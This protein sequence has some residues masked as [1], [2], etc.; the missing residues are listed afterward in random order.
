M[1]SSAAV[2]P[3]KS[4]PPLKSGSLAG[5]WPAASTHEHSDITPLPEER[6]ISPVAG[7]PVSV[8]LQPPYTSGLGF[9]VGTSILSKAST[10]PTYVHLIEKI[11]PSTPAEK[12]G[13]VP[14]DHLVEI[15]GVPCCYQD[16]DTIS[17]MILK[18]KEVG[19]PIRIDLSRTTTPTSGLSTSV[20]DTSIDMAKM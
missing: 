11:K 17:S 4:D 5:K 12:A 1:L 7:E 8:L 20:S 9:T 10:Y 15:D 3:K 2:G 19:N 16:H 6:P 13:M 18:T 14:G